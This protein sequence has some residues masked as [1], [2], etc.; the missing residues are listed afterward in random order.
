MSNDLYFMASYDSPYP[1][2]TEVVEWLTCYRTRQYNEFFM[3]EDCLENGRSE[4]LHWCDITGYTE[5][6]FF[7]HCI[8]L[9]RGRVQAERDCTTFRFVQ[10]YQWRYME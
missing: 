5:A 6:Q 2:L 1:E 7:A 9:G 8:Y 4:C 3:C 10:T